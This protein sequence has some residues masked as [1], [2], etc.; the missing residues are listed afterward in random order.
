MKRLLLLL[1]FGLAACSRLPSYARPQGSLMDPGTIDSEDLIEYRT[2]TPQDFRGDK[3]VGEAAQHM[4]A[5]G[6]Q[7]Y[8]IVRPDPNLKITITGT[9]EADG[10]THYK[11]KLEAKLHF[12]AQMDR[13]RSW[14]NPNLKEVP[15]EYVLQ[16]EQIHFAIA[17][18]EAK[19]LNASAA[20]VTA[21]MHAEGDSQ[22]EVKNAIQ[23][24]LDDVIRDALDRLIERNGKFDE[25]T[26]AR[27]APKKQAEWWRRVQ[28][29]L[30]GAGD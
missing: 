13:K 8:A 20:A 7:T 22:E 26:S 4:D 11:G 27:Y 2:L 1:L 21:R 19:N 6:A 29:E 24:K 18:I 15:I 12:R 28:A 9:R 17:A 16:H 5:M 10:D 23:A 14:W 30:G 25:D 3:P